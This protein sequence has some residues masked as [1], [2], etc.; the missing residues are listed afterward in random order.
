MLLHLCNTKKAEILFYSSIIV[1]CV[2]KYSFNRWISVGTV[3]AYV[4]MTNGKEVRLCLEVIEVARWVK[5][6]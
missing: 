5:V 1:K 6:P 2:P 4:Y 3:Y